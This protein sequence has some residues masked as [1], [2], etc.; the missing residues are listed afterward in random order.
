MTSSSAGGG[1]RDLEFTV[2]VLQMIW[3]GREAELRSPRLLTVLPELERLGHVSA[4][5]AAALQS[6]YRFLRDTEH[7]IQALADE[8][9]QKLPTS[10]A[11]RLA[12]AQMMGFADFAEFKATLDDHRQHVRRC[13]D[14]AVAPAEAAPRS[15]PWDEL[16]AAELSAMDFAE[17]QR[18]AALLEALKTARN[19]QSVAVEGRERLDALMPL[20]LDDL[21]ARADAG[22][23]LSR[24]VPIL[25]AILRRSAYLVLLRENPGARQAL[26]ALLARSQW[27]AD[28]VRERPMQL[29]VLL[30]DRGLDVIPDRA[31][32]ADE[33]RTRIDSV[34]EEG[35]E[36]VLDALREF[37]QH[38][39]LAV[40]VAELRGLLPVMKASDCYTYLAQVLLG[41]ALDVAWRDC[42]GP[43]QRPFVIV[44]YGKLGGNELG[45]NSDLDLVFVHDLGSDH[46]QF[47]H[48]LARRLMHVLTAPTYN[49]PLYE[50]DMRLRPSGNAG[51]MISSLASFVE[52]QQRHA[53]TWE[54]QALVRARAVAG[55]AHLA[56]RFEV[57]RRELICQPRDLAALR[58]DVLEMRRRLGQPSRCCCRPQAG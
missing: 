7:S 34:R 54:A 20:I 23:V 56:A 52:Y 43:D 48:R 32:L 33:L 28:R 51:T 55:D 11:E 29:D 47:L 19:R 6:A 26:V 40:A 50:I 44:G 5:D 10:A 15:V 12:V 53:W 27:L 18:C 14:A 9:T 1:I 49:G 46:A 57:V 30:D 41:E 3:G 16:S 22:L 4:Q 58:Q 2:Q 35:E 42:D 25:R 37:R 31:R 21:K 45:P 38:H 39:A 24:L 13:F 17:P 8:Q 36:R